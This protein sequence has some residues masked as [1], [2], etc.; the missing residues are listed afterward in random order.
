MNQSPEDDATLSSKV[1]SLRKQAGLTGQALARRAGMSQSTISK[2]ETGKLLPSRD[3]VVNLARAL[4]V[5][6]DT[7]NELLAFVEDLDQQLGAWGCPPHAGSREDQW[8]RKAALSTTTVRIFQSSFIPSFLQTPEYAAEVRRR[9]EIVTSGDVGE[10]ALRLERQQL[11]SRS[12]REFVVVMTESAL[13]LRVG[14]AEEM[15]AQLNWVAELSRR[16]DIN[17][18]IIALDTELPVVPHNNFYV[19]D[20]LLVTTELIT[21]EIMFRSTRDVASYLKA[22]SLLQRAATFGERASEILSDIAASFD[23]GGRVLVLS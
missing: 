18:G 22:F 16:D 21:A 2:I 4:A 8:V 20:D 12:A 3:Q 10:V 13:R 9:A 7:A 17:M 19:F 1:R 6:S 5:S 23:S 11:L 15:I 14:S